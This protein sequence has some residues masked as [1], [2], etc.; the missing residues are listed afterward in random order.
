MCTYN[1]EAHV[2]LED[3]DGVITELY[4]RKIFDI[5]VTFITN[6]R[7]FPDLSCFI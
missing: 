7:I 2:I 3:S 6:I 4:Q 1:W 5:K